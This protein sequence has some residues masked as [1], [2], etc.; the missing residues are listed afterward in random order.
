LPD[1]I[2]PERDTTVVY[3]LTR[4]DVSGRITDHEILD[5]LGWQPGNR[6]AS[7]FDEPGALALRPDPAGRM[8]VAPRQRITL[9]ALLRHRCAISLG[10]TVFLTALTQHG[11]LLMRTLAWLDQALASHNRAGQPA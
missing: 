1:A 8:V 4:V 9:P 11:V 5:A 6:L 7:T 2:P 3:A 10:D